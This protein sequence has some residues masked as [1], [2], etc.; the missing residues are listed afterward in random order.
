M[1]NRIQG[2]RGEA[3]DPI[4]EICGLE[5]LLRLLIPRNVIVSELRLLWKNALLAGKAKQVRGE[6]EE[7][8]YESKFSSSPAPAGCKKVTG[9]PKHPSVSSI[10]GHTKM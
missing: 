10:G 3:T 5:C 6:R 7:N 1:S 9:P 2:Q 4:N 8:T